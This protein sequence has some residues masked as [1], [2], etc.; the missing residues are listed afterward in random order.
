M[1]ARL[2]LLFLV[3]PIIELAVLYWLASTIT[4]PWTV[5]I[6]LSTGIVG[7]WLARSQGLRVFRRVHAEVNLG[8]LPTNDLLDGL[9]II[10]A[11]ALLIT[12]GL[13]TDLFG[14]SLL[15]APLRSLYR[16]WLAGWM[17]R[18]FRITT[19]NGSSL[20]A[21]SPFD[22]STVVDSYVVREEEEEN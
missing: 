9:L 13:L 21:N 1:L 10:I 20:H 16:H 6:A 8:R 14:L 19:I 17:K 22:R 15:I 11:G 5:V 2:L 18:R 12:P 4:L 3:F 7:A